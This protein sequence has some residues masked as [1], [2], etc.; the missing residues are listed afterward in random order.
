[1]L[2]PVGNKLYFSADGTLGRELWVS[3]GTSSGTRLLCDIYPGS[4]DSNPEYLTASGGKLYFAATT[5]TLG[6]ELF[7]LGWVADGE[8]LWR[9]LRDQS[10]PRSTP[11]P[12][13]SANPSRPSATTRPGRQVCF[14]WGRPPRRQRPSSRSPGRTATCTSTRRSTCSTIQ[15]QGTRWKLT[16]TIPND[17]SMVGGQWVMQSLYGPL[18]GRTSDALL[19]TIGR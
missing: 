14:W 8:R 4:G 15:P 7:E 19:L 3:D 16:Q 6:T 9:R 5:P 12:R 13:S 10:L 18:P 1:M 11:P 2:R 17:S